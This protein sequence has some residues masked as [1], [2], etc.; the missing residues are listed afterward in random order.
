MAALV[1]RAAVEY[2]CAAQLA[3]VVLT[4]AVVRAPPKICE[5]VLRPTLSVR[6]DLAEAFL[7]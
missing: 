2:P 5:S 3:A 6:V 4:W 1:R 7:A